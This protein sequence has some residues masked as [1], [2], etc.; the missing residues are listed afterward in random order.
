MA[1]VSTI[2][3]PIIPRE[4]PTTTARKLRGEEKENSSERQ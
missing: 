1:T 2:R 4:A 3:P